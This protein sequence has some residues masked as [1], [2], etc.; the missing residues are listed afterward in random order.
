MA[1]RFFRRSRHVS[2]FEGSFLNVTNVIMSLPAPPPSLGARVRFVDMFWSSCIVGAALA[3][4][5]DQRLQ[6]A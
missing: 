2:M 1:S 6:A 4:D 5:S 3:A